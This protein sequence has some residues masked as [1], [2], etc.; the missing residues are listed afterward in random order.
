MHPAKGDN[1]RYYPPWSWLLEDRWLESDRFLLRQFWPI[2]RTFWLVFGSVFLVWTWKAE[3][4]LLSLPD[5]FRFSI[6]SSKYKPHHWRNASKKPIIWLYFQYLYIYT[7][8]LEVQATKQ[9]MIF[10][11]CFANLPDQPQFVLRQVLGLTFWSIFQ[12][13]AM[14]KIIK[15][16]SWVPLGEYPRYIPT[17]TTYIWAM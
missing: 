2:F 4:Q 11:M 13:K 9:R 14:G 7:Y 16:K 12:P 1:P 17:Y 10:E 6:K 3:F 15:G 5:V 8:T